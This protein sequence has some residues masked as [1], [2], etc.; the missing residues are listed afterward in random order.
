M[1]LV[2]G[3]LTALA[4]ARPADTA[5]VVDRLGRCVESAATWGGA[6]LDAVPVARVRERILVA[7]NEA[8]L[9][10]GPLREVIGGA[11]GTGGPGEGALARAGRAAAAEDVVRGLPR[12]LDEPIDAQSRNLSGGQRQR[13][14]LAR[15]LLADPEVLL[16]VEPT[17]ALDAHTEAVIAARLREVRSGRTTLLVTGS[18]LLL[19]RAD[20]VYH[21]VDGK[22][23]AHGPHERLLAGSPEYRALVSRDD[24]GPDDPDDPDDPGAPVAT[25]GGAGADADAEEAVR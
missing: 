14:R 9:F 10:A 11:A 5:A 21:L 13:V 22:V 24:D 23:A 2:P 16:A 18:P 15:A 3:L 1:R 8:D 6:R 17:S 25:C 20:T 7:D 12:G 19:E 4:G